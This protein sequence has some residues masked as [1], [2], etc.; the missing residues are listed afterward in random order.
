VSGWRSLRKILQQLNGIL[1]ANSFKQG[2]GSLNLQHFR[3]D[4]WPI[5]FR[6]QTSDTPFRFD[7][8]PIFFEHTNKFMLDGNPKSIESMI[9][10][11]LRH[12]SA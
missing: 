8:N 2:N 12:S 9:V 1:G 3:R 5:G 10:F 7:T 11:C 6:Q 4:D